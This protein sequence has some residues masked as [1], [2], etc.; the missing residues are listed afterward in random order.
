MKETLTTKEAEMQSLYVQSEDLCH[1]LKMET[2]HNDRLRV[3]VQQE[4]LKFKSMKKEH[5]MK[6]LRLTEMND[7]VSSLESK[8]NKACV[9]KDQAPELKKYLVELSRECFSSNNKRHVADPNESQARE[10]DSVRRKMKS[11]EDILKRNAKLHDTNMG[12]L[13]RENKLLHKV[14]EHTRIC[15]CQCIATINLTSICHFSNSTN[16]TKRSIA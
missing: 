11:T 12:R 5:E 16:S 15:P 6:T 8:V 9:I 13:G 10:C 14:G 2:E 3:K 7:E 1:K 4:Q